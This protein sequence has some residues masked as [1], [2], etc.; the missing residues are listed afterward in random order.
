MAD[1]PFDPAAN[2][3]TP[4]PYEQTYGGQKGPGVEYEDGQFE[5]ETEDIQVNDP[6]TPGR[7]GSYETQNLGGYGTGQPNAED[8]TFANEH[9]VSP[10]DT[11]AKQDNQ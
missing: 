7:T 11:E 9:P 5:S 10:T 3:A 1:K 6:T 4:K 2:K 8:Q